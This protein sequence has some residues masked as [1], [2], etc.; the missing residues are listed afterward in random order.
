MRFLQ[1]NILIV[2]FIF[3]TT[4]LFFLQNRIVPFFSDDIGWIGSVSGESVI[5]RFKDFVSDQQNMWLTQNGRAANNFVW[6][7]T[8]CGGELCYDIFISLTFLAVIFLIG[9]IAGINNCK[10]SVFLWVLIPFFLLYLS[11][12]HSSNFYWAGGGCHYLWPCFL[13][14]LFLIMLKRNQRKESL[15]NFIPLILLSFFA[16]WSHEIFALPISLSLFCLSLYSII[17]KNSDKPKKKQWLMIF[18]YWLGTLLIVVSPGTRNRIGGTMN[19]AEI[20]FLQAIA[21]KL[22]TSFKIFRYG[23]CF[24]GILFI[25]IYSYLLKTEAFKS[26]VRNNAFWFIALLGNVGIVVILG[27]GGRAVWGVEV[28]SFI[29][30]LR[31]LDGITI[32]QRMLLNRIGIFLSIL[33]VVHQAILLKPFKESWQTYD[34]VVEQTKQAGFRGTA[35]M[36]DWQSSNPLIDSFVAH[37]YAMMMQDIW[38]R[39]PL[40]CNVCK[41]EVYDALTIFEDKECSDKVSNIGGDFI[42]L[43]DDS[44]VE[45][46]REGRISIELEPISSNM[47]GGFLFIFWHSILQK[48][49]PDRYPASI[50]TIYEEEYSVLKIGGKEF[51]R[52]EKPIRPIARTILDVEILAE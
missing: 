7:L 51:I 12:D 39:V 4:G 31:W 25:V 30:I 10:R 17:N 37:P 44:K 48:V 52:F 23:R 28:F 8:I 6:Q 41:S 40:R 22:V 33:L 27:V 16:G 20:P 49:W 1:R 2:L 5:G 46:I 38:M 45:S 21:A 32:R 47:R 15:S 29:L 36:E 3:A 13:S 42:T 18:A 9:Q 24:Y 35:R 43:Y 34:N 19:G 14:L 50:N 26:F 11:P